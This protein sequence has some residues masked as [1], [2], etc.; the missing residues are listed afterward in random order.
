MTRRPA[1]SKASAGTAVFRFS[2]WFAAWMLLG[3][4]LATEHQSDLRA[5]VVRPA[6]VFLRSPV[7]PADLHR[8][9]VLPLTSE[10]QGENLSEGCEALAPVLLD[11]VVKTRR[12]EVV[13]VN[14][15]TL[16][17][18]SGR[19]AWTGTEALPSGFFDS[20]QR[21]YGCDALL[22]CQLTTYHPYS[23]MLIGWRLKLVDA[24]THQI[25]WSADEVFES[26]PK[27][28]GVVS[29]A[30]EFLYPHDK[31]LAAE[32][33]QW[34][35]AHSPRQFGRYAVAQLLRTLPER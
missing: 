2:G 5:A 35:E 11:E 22:F 10:S 21:E 18:G 19:L 33:K 32:G 30:L 15:E 8:V 23:P 29:D 9:A 27:G 20:L 13:S 14:A 17:S 3:G 25:L 4:N 34:A 16:R 31:H 1:N 26:R 7:L 12:F 24:H 28:P 6:N